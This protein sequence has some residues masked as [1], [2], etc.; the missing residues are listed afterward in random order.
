MDNNTQQQ[1]DVIDLA[2]ILKII[3]SKKAMFPKVWVI[4]FILSCVWIFPQP[5]YYTC[6]VRLA[7]ETGTEATA[8]GLASIA[9][10][11]GF[12]IGGAS[13]NDAIYP[14][15]YPELFLSPEFIVGLFDIE[16]TKADNSI[17]TDYFT[18]LTKHQQKNVLT[19]PFKK[20]MRWI[21]S[22]FEEKKAGTTQGH[23]PFR[24]SKQEEDVMHVIQKNIACDIDKK[25][26]VISIIVQDQ[27]PLIAA[28]LADSVRGRLQD[29]II[30]Y[31]TKKS[32]LDLEY[33]KHLTDSARQE[34]YQA[35]NVYSAFCDSHRDASLQ[36]VL[37]QRERLEND[38]QLKNS[39]YQAM[40]TQLQAMKAKVQ[41]RTPAFT[42]LQSPT[43]P[44]KPA[45]P[46]RV[47][48]VLGMLFLATFAS[49]LWIPR[50]YILGIKK[51]EEHTGE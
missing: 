20:A 51:E 17:K 22:L 31:R 3:W 5:R 14:M 32:R 8:G 34:Y 21:K 49:C 36:S 7:P 37:S 10:N 2:Q 27:D 43:V 40:M 4:T 42:V 44:I 33:Y 19:H 48:F 9:S 23:D 39:T 46:K 12:N 30:E 45:R 35:Q 38:L 18:Y 11:F 41:E 1:Q 50:N 29:F 6:E 28:T 13:G 24:L 26:E 16:V 25:T 47:L 15:L